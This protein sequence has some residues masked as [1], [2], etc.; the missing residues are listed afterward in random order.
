[1]DFTA[2]ESYLSTSVSPN[3]VRHSLS[4]AETA[5]NLARRFCDTHVCADDAYLVGLWHDM[6]REWSGEALLNHCLVHQLAMEQEEKACPILLHGPVAADLLPAQVPCDSSLQRAVR[7]HTL[8]SAGMGAL[9]AV[10][11]IADYAEP[12]RTH[13]DETQR[14]AIFSLGSLEQMCLH[15]V[16]MSA[17]YMRCRKGLPLAESTLDLQ[18]YLQAGGRFS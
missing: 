2:I 14:Q 8:G 18:R 12:L 11:F 9:G 17:D 4:T 5:R 3:R 13:L 1:M 10:L 16:A 15:I 6:A 7:W